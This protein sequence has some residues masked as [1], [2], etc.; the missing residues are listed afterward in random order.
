[1]EIMMMT[2]ATPMMTPNIVS[3]ELLSRA[4]GRLYAIEL[5][6][7]DGIIESEPDEVE[8]LAVGRVIC[9]SP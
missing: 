2:A 1:M 6:V 4:N 9:C 7:S 5:T 3:K 8:V